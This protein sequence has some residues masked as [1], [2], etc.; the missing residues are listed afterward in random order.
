MNR[1]GLTFFWL[2]VEVV[3]PPEVSLSLLGWRWG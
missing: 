3:S 1:K 2:L